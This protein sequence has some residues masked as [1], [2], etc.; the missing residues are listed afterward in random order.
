M[1]WITPATRRN[2]RSMVTGQSWQC[3]PSISNFRL[4]VR[5]AAA[6]ASF[7]ALRTSPRQQAPEGFL[8]SQAHR[9][10]FTLAAMRWGMEQPPVAATSARTSARVWPKQ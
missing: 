10:A 6:S 7:T 1:L 3:I 4:R 2:R 9:P 8:T 5:R